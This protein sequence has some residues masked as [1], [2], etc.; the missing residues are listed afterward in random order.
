MKTPR[1]DLLASL[2]LVVAPL[3]SQCAPRSATQ[4]GTPAVSAVVSAHWV[5]VS[6]RPPTFYPQGVPADCATDIRSGEW[7]ST[8]NASNTRFFIPFKGIAPAKRR[9]LI[10]EALALQ[11]EK[12]RNQIDKESKVDATTVAVA[13]TAVAV[14]P[15]VFPVFVAAEIV[16]TFV[17]WIYEPMWVRD[18]KAARGHSSTQSEN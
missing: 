16:G 5:Q 12:K 17:P 14:T 8:E 4:A 10:Q 15:V 6:S 9:A 7:V 1:P 3:L 18:A 11:S 13:A 2:I